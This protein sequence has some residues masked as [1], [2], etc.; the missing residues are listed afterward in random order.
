MSLKRKRVKEGHGI[1]FK[2]RKKQSRIAGVVAAYDSSNTRV[3]ISI[4]GFSNTGDN[5]LSNRDQ[6]DN[7]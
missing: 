2:R 3:G 1:A 6:L 7:Q 5:E 4:S